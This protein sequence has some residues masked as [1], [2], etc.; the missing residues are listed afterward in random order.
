MGN[1][2]L[3]RNL[4]QPLRNSLQTALAARGLGP[5]GI[6]WPL[7]LFDAACF[8]LI[9]IALAPVATY[10]YRV[11]AARFSRRGLSAEDGPF[12]LAAMTALGLLGWLLLHPSQVFTLFNRWDHLAFCALAGG[13]LAGA[14]QTMRAWGLGLLSVA[15]LWEHFGSMTMFV[16]L[17]TTLAAF[18]ALHWR[19]RVNALALTAIALV[20]YGLCWYLRQTSFWTGLLVSGLFFKLL[21]RQISAAAT[22]AGSA[23]PRLGNYLCYVTFYPGGFGIAFGP[24]VWADFSR[25]NFG[26]RPHLDARLAARR[27]VSGVLQVWISFRIPISGVDLDAATGFLSAWGGSLLLFVSAALFLMGVWSLVEA[28][29]LF[30]GFR[31]HP[32]FRGI[33]TRRNPSELWWAWRGTFTNWLVRHVYAPLGAN[34]RHQSLNIFAAFGVSLLWHALGAPFVTKDFSLFQVAPVALWALINACAVTAHLAVRRRGLRLLPEATPA[35]LRRG[36]HTFLTL[37]LGSFAVTFL[38]FHSHVENFVPFLR[39]LLGLSK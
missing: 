27:V 37:C 10:L 38:R 22:A 23:P 28:A 26:R 1:P 31:L 19:G 34:E 12:A 13:V 35:L 7:E 17:G 5:P 36:I 11:S 15:F 9:A 16:A 18:G 21:L 14:P 20:A 4:A 8:G 6:T 30:Y 33:L 39:L 32:N 25:R 24:E 2:D 3:L 29:A